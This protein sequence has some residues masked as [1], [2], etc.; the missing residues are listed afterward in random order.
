MPG[1][2]LELGEREEIR[3]GLVRGESLRQI[4]RHIERPVSTIAREVDR[5]GGRTRSV[6]ACA[7]LRAERCA[8]RPKTRGSEQIL[9]WPGVS[10]G[11]W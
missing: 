3:V 4:A 11:A 9:R 8:R 5:N 7:Q 10:P 2:R 1:R 6:A